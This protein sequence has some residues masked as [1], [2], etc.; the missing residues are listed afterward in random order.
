MTAALLAVLA[1][2][3]RVKP[4]EETFNVAAM[5][6]GVVDWVR[7]AE[8][9]AARTDTPASLIL[10]MIWQESSG[11]PDAVGSAG[12]IGLMQLKPLAIIDAERYLGLEPGALDP[13]VGTDNVLLG[14]AYLANQIEITGNVDDGIRAYNQGVT[15]AKRN[16]EAA[17]KY[18][19]SVRSKWTTIT[20]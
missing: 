4:E 8:R 5:P 6:A 18:F 1:W 11:N 7:S 3:F 2:L 14:A 9:A 20:N 17:N 12:E 15:G 13:T 10:A 19:N 16:P